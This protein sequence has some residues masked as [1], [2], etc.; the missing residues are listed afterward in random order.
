MYSLMKCSVTGL[1]S[2]VELLEDNIKEKG[3]RSQ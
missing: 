1:R 2:M 3:I